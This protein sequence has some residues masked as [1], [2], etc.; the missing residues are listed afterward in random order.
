MKG[1]IKIRQKPNEHTP[2]ITVMILSIYILI[3]F[4]ER[5]TQS[6]HIQFELNDFV[7]LYF[8]PTILSSG[9]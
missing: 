5:K 4:S 8:S 2:L 1:V 3:L 7:L 9:A 6:N